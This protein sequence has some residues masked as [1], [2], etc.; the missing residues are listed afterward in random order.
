MNTSPWLIRCD[1]PP[2]TSWPPNLSAAAA[3]LVPCGD[4][5]GPAA[6]Q[7]YGEKGLN[8]LADFGYQGRACELTAIQ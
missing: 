3:L 1:S 6:I 4:R 5:S 2:C 7:L 8:W